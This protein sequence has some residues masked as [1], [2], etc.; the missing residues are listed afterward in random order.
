MAGD[1]EIEH[2][3]TEGN[4]PD[5]VEVEDNGEE[6]EDIV[7]PEIPTNGV[8][9]EPP[10][11]PV[12]AFDPLEKLTPKQMDALE[13][14]RVKAQEYAEDDDERKWCNDMC[15]LRYLRARDY[16]V[17][18]SEKMLEATL[19]W[20][21][22]TAADTYTFED[23][24]PIARTG[25]VYMNGFDK[26]GRPIL[27]MRPY[28][29][30]TLKEEVPTEV[31]FKH[32]R[33]WLEKAMRS[34]DASKGVE[35]F[36]IFVDYKEYGRKVMDTKTNVHVLHYMLNHLPERLGVA[37]FMDPPFL[38]WV[39]WKFI[40]P[41]LNAVTLAKVK[42][43]SSKVVDGK[44]SC[45]DLLEIIDKE[46]LEEEFSGDSKKVYDYDAYVN[47]NYELTEKQ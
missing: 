8:H 33:Y 40:S 5:A 34:M 25:C 17:S 26:F 31:K 13:E 45:P 29:Q 15:L 47:N 38:F 37:I 21:R 1:Q 39:G 24:E 11:H 6:G 44:R 28:K 30:S 19:K 46:T 22:E 16:N 41:F 14:M 10:P 7:V 35:K 27:M 42:F 2:V 3:N 18:K 4:T 36:C 9:E 12:D 20:R 43:V 23:V 32:L